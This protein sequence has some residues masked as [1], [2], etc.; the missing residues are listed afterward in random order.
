MMN[1]LIECRSNMERIDVIKKNFMIRKIPFI[2]EIFQQDTF[3]IYKIFFLTGAC[4]VGSTAAAVWC[5]RKF[6]RFIMI[7]IGVGS[8]RHC[9]R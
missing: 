9:W 3:A 5:L 1:R 7:K 6:Q 8:E 4:S 2:V